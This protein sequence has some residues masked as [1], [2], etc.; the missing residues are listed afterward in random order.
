MARAGDELRNDRTEKQRIV[1]R[2]TAKETGG[3]LLEMEAF[4]KPGGQY[5]P[6]HYHPLQDEHFEV[7]SGQQPI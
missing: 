4:Y 2:K 1:L 3:T 5:P 6:E 7:I